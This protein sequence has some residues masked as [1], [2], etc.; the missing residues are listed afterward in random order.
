LGR[1]PGGG[2][3]GGIAGFVLFG[4]YLLNGYR[5]SVPARAGIAKLSWF[6]WTAKHLPLAGQYDWW[7]LVP[8]AIAAAGVLAIGVEA[9]SRRD[10]GSLSAIR[11]PSAPAA[12]LGLPG[13]VGRSLAHLLPPPPPP[14][15]PL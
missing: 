6:S 13:P 1:F 12:L 8:V 15:P 11:T 9:F 3:G 10:L 14:H 7:S 5:A 4:G 2:G